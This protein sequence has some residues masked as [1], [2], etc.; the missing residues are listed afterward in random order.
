MHRAGSNVSITVNAR[1]EITKEVRMAGRDAPSCIV[2][3]AGLAGL[4]AA[5]QLTKSGWKVTVLEA[6]WRPG[7]RVLSHR[8]TKNKTLVCELGGEWIGSQHTKITA[9]CKEFGLPLVTHRFGFSF[10]NGARGARP[11]IYKPGAWPFSKKA[12]RSFNRFRREYE[13]RTDDEGWNRALDKLDWWTQLQKLKFTDQELLRRDLMD[14]TDFGET[15]RVTSAYAAAGEYFDSN[16]TDEMDS[17]IVGGNDLL[18]KKLAKAIVSAG[19][20]VHLKSRVT[21]VHQPAVASKRA[22][23]NSVRVRVAGRSTTYRADFCICAL[24]APCLNKIR[25][26]PPLRH[27]KRVAADQL[28]YAR[29]VKTAVLYDR[30]FWKRWPAAGFSTFTGRVSDFCFDST[31]LQEGMQGIL[32]SYAIGDKADDVAG[33][34]DVNNVKEWLTEDM[35]HVVSARQ[36]VRALAIIRHPWQ[37]DKF[38]GGAYALYRP[39]EWFRIQPAL[40]RPFGQVRF[41]GEHIAEWQGFMEGAVVTGQK[42]ARSIARSIRGAA[43]SSAPAAPRKHGESARGSAGSKRPP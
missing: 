19:G 3:G 32:C 27:D 17:K 20:T 41:A 5:H 25:W 39:G 36:S 12:Q 21:A 33:E 23:K 8:F 34:P 1:G 24:P 2:L 40:A 9:L 26:E 30:R 15:T 22:I 7:G 28:Q 4:S 16:D 14:S 11:R 38:T 31:Y 13:K 29:I 42:A 35:K 10:W 18:A 6:T 43:S 37:H